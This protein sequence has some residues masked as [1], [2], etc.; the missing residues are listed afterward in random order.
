MRFSVRRTTP[1]LSS[2]HANLRMTSPMHLALWAT[3][4]KDASRMHRDAAAEQNNPPEAKTQAHLAY[5]DLA[6]S[7]SVHRTEVQCLYVTCV[8]MFH[9]L[10]GA[11]TL[12]LYSNL[13]SLSLIAKTLRRPRGDERRSLP[14]RLSRFAL[15]RRRDALLNCASRA[16]ALSPCSTT[17][18]GEMILLGRRN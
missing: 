2:P 3:R 4:P 14:V 6:L 5:H 7:P 16:V 17:L 11:A 12:R 9:Q 15:L 18:A 10:P 1:S 8:P 13:P